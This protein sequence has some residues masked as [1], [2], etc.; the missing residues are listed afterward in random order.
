MFQGSYCYRNVNNSTV[1]IQINKLSKYSCLRS[2]NE[3]TNSIKDLNNII[4][5]FSSIHG[6]FNDIIRFFNCFKLCNVFF[7]GNF[8][9]IQEKVIKFKTLHFLVRNPHKPQIQH[10]L[11]EKKINNSTNA[12]TPK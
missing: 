11:S 8:V 9:S 7:S 2:R 5:V 4:F 1:I 3:Y 10:Y 12:R 6:Q